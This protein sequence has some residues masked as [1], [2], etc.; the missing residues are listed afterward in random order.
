MDSLLR[1][2]G[3]SLSFIGDSFHDG[4]VINVDQITKQINSNWQKGINELPT[5][6]DIIRLLKKIKVLY[7]GE[8]VF[9]ASSYDPQATKEELI[10]CLCLTI[11][12]LVDDQDTVGRVAANSEK[13]LQPNER[14]D[15]SRQLAHFLNELPNAIFVRILKACSQNMVASAFL[16]LRQALGQDFTFKDV[17]NGWSI[18]IYVDDSSIQVAHKRSEQS[19]EAERFQFSWE[20]NMIF[21][22]EASQLTNI[23]LQVTQLNFGPKERKSSQTKLHKL[24]RKCSFTEGDSTVS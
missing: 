6:V 24:L 8:E 1:K 21:D 20:L 14:S 4:M 13:Y 23:S 19:T 12:S 16:E 3:S 7:K 11:S 17:T 2:V 9:Y 15:L 18:Q 5:T 10:T 22:R